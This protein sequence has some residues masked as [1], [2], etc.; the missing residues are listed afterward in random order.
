MKVLSAFFLTAIIP[1][2][3][4]LLAMHKS[5]QSSDQAKKQRQ[6][7]KRRRA[8]IHLVKEIKIGQLL[9]KP[10]SPPSTY[11]DASPYLQS[12]VQKHNDTVNNQGK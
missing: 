8:D 10:I 5:T 1:M 12:L 9:H 7:D 6:E 4:W 3:T 2:N 11:L